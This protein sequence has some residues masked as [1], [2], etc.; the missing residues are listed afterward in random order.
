MSFT[1]KDRHTLEQLN[2][3]A[4]EASIRLQEAINVISR[5]ESRL[6]VLEH[7]VEAFKRTNGYPSRRRIWN[8]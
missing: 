4:S 2:K 8:A 3:D 5:I 1:P 7:S 6:E